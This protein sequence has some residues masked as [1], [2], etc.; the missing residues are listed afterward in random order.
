MARKNNGFV[1]YESPLHFFRLGKKYGACDEK[2]LEKDYQP[3]G[4]QQSELLII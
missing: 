2:Y 4:N 3:C 1:C